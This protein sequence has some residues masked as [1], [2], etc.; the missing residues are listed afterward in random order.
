MSDI[1]R[2]VDEEV[3]RDKAAEFWA[4]HG[5]KVIVAATLIV[6]SVAGWRF[7]EHRSFQQNAALGS[8][9][10]QAITDANAGKAD[11]SK[12]LEALAEQ[13]SGTY[14]ALAKFRLAAELARAAKDDASLAN[15]VSAFDALSK[16]ATLPAD[17]REI[18]QIRAALLL[19]DKGPFEEVEKRLAGMTAGTHAFRHT[20]REAIAQAAYQA[21]K[22]DKAL[23]ALQAI[24]LDS[25]AP[26]ALRQRAELLLAV[27]R[28]GPVGAKP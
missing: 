3:R 2:E 25:E 23:D 27:V 14:P 5:T 21:G 10:E 7:Y 22:F 6:A 9:F 13:K 28:S 17:W 11:A 4:K 18:A 16:D 15:A 24:I 26:Q 8:S 12:A 1:F 20:A 19:V